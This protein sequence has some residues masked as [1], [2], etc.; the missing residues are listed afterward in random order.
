MEGLVTEKQGPKLVTALLAVVT[1]EP[2]FRGDAAQQFKQHRADCKKMLTFLFGCHVAQFPAKASDD[3][4]R[5]NDDDE[6]EDA[7]LQCG[8]CVRI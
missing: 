1:S 7:R 6:D 2:D 4:C 3:H 8:G 5:D